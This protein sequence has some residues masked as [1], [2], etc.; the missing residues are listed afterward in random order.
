MVK[1]LCSFFIY[2]ARK[3]HS[4][5]DILYEIGEDSHLYF[6]F[7]L[8]IGSLSLKD[9]DKLTETLYSEFPGEERLMQ[10]V[11][12]FFLSHQKKLIKEIASH[13]NS[14]ASPTRLQSHEGTA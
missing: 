13:L 14:Q 6:W 7:R 11:N 10:E 1:P 2:L 3:H 12:F 9:S 5:S 8:V 4:L